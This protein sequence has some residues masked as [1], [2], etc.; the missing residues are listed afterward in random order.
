LELAV[1][2]LIG[3]CPV[4]VLGAIDLGDSDSPSVCDNEIGPKVALSA[5][6]AGCGQ[7][8]DGRFR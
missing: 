8:P 6:E 3:R 5:P 1:P 7:D 2:G 4:A